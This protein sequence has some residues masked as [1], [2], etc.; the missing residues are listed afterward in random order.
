VQTRVLIAFACGVLLAIA[1]VGLG[2]WQQRRGDDKLA[3]QRQWDTALAAPARDMR[4]ADLAALAGRLPA[5]VRLRG[6]F[7][8]QRL[9]WL[10]NRQ[11]EGRP[12]VRAIMALRLDDGSR[13]LVDRGWAPRDPRDRARTPQLAT[14]ASAVTLEGLA[15]ERAPRLLDLGGASPGEER[16]PAMWQ[17]LEYERFERA[18][19]VPVARIIVQQTSALDDGLV[20][21]VPR[22][23]AGVERHRGYAVQWYALAALSGGLT[24]FFGWRAWRGKREPA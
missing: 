24:A 6:V 20:R 3:L 9:V 5:R 11:H 10:D 23:D 1:A 16:L 2:Q 8:P 15:L 13:V 12:G 4:S 7:E 22:F 19:G 21:D 18:A 14:P 17:N